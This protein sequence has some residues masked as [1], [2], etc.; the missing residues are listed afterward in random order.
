MSKYF[1]FF[2]KKNFS[3]KFLIRFSSFLSI[4]YNLNTVKYILNLNNL[5]SVIF[6]K[7]IEK[8][9]IIIWK[10]IIFKKNIRNSYI[11]QLYSNLIN[12]FDICLLYP[13]IVK[14]YIK[15]NFYFFPFNSHLFSPPSKG[16]DYCMEPYWGLKFGPPLFITLVNLTLTTYL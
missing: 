9:V 1:L 11:V 4:N 5:N 15:L 7:F 3:T 10:I 13:Q 6:I 16:C 14:Y 12:V 2:E 8:K